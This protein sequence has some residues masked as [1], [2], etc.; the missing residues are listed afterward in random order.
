MKEGRG[1][2]NN[3]DH[4]KKKKCLKIASANA[5]LHT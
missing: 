2:V 1:L 4:W 3:F 5:E